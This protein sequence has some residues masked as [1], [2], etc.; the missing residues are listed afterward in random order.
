MIFLLDFITWKLQKYLGS[1]IKQ[2]IWNQKA[3]R[4]FKKFSTKFMEEFSSPIKIISFLVSYWWVLHKKKFYCVWIWNFSLG[5]LP[6]FLLVKVLPMFLAVVVALR[7]FYHPD[8]NFVLKR[9]APS[10][11]EE[12]FYVM[13]LR[14]SIT[15]LCLQQLF[16]KKSWILVKDCPNLLA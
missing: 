5:V 9:V 3:T 2:R 7:I 14:S 12:W 11:L 10:S 15:I 13:E 16:L 8:R 1:F 6:F 4:K